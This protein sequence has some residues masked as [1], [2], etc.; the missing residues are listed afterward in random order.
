MNDVEKW[1]Y[2]GAGVSEGLRLLN[3][4]APNCHWLKDGM[5]K[6]P[7]IFRRILMEKLESLSAYGKP[8]GSETGVEETT[9]H[10]RKFREEWTFLNDP[11]CPMEL[12]VLASDKITTWQ[13]YTS[14]HEDLFA[15]STVKECLETARKVVENYWRNR[16]I[17]SEFVYYK[18]HHAVLGEDKVFAESKKLE[19][20]RRLSI[21]GLIKKKKATEDAIWRVKSEM[22][23]GDKP[24]LLAERRDRLAEKQ[25][26]L[27]AITEMIEDYERKSAT[28]R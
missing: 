27:A 18:E 4:Y 10:K 13:N 26:T 16:K 15:C 8:S 20:Y 3:I 7:G 19:S 1:I 17:H 9:Q 2:S 24:H 22:R 5:E 21:I 25:R 12:K 28:R 11:D 23:K 14:G 6:A